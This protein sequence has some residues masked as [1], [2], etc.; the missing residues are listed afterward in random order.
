MILAAVLIPN[1]IKGAG[2]WSNPVFP[3]F[4]AFGLTFFLIYFLVVI[5]YEVVMLRYRGATLGKMACG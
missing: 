1:M 3:A 4:A 5:C 2:R